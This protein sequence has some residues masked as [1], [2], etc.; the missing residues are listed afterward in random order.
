MLPVMSRDP[1][2]AHSAPVSQR[3]L[4][5]VLRN[6]SGRGGP[7]GFNP[8]LPPAAPCL[9]AGIWEGQQGGSQPLAPSSL[10]LTQTPGWA[11]RHIHPHVALPR[12]CGRCQ[13]ST[14]LRGGVLSRLCARAVPKSE[15]WA[16][17]C[18]G[19]EGFHGVGASW[20]CLWHRS[21]RVVIPPHGT[22][23]IR[24][25]HIHSAGR[26]DE[27]EGREKPP[28]PSPVLLVSLLR[29]G[30]IRDVAC[31]TPWD[32]AVPTESAPGMQEKPPLSAGI[33]KVLHMGVAHARAQ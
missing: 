2:R 17:S 19:W 18:H 33:G 11:G 22:P 3:E 32:V 26:K 24:L 30:G 14:G 8:S 25:A 31:P 13:D 16:I 20:T 23:G 10:C 28:A 6:P 7:G 4:W 29:F 27:A 15:F 5:A 1:R 21:P 9:W 12:W